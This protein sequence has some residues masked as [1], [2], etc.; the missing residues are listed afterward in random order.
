[1]SPAEAP[2]GPG[3][4]PEGAAGFLEAVEAILE[5]EEA[6][7]CH[8]IRWGWR[9][10]SLEPVRQVLAPVKPWSGLSWWLD[11]SSSSLQ[12]VLKKPYTRRQVRRVLTAAHRRL[13]RENS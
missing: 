3:A 6:D 5:R 2:G 8:G 9:P 11:Q 10:A 13:A 7:L 4:L 1:M 12:G